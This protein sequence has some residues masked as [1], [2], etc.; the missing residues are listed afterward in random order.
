[1]SVDRGTADAEGLGDLGGA[2]A[3]GPPGVSGGELV[4]VHDG[5]PSA[6]LTL[7]PGGGQ[8]GHGALVDE[9][10]LELG[11]GDDAPADR[12]PQVETGQDG[13]K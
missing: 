3:A 1:M 11:E 13:L 10:P 12:A 2:L 6:G 8:A 4:R 7:S 5:G 9:V